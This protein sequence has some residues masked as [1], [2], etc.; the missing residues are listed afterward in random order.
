MV[1]SKWRNFFFE[2]RP[3]KWRALV[4]LLWNVIVKCACGFELVLPGNRCYEMRIGSVLKWWLLK[5]INWVC[6]R[7]KEKFKE[8]SS[9]NS[10]DTKLLP[11]I[12]SL[13]I[14][15]YP[16]TK[17]FFFYVN[18]VWIFFTKRIHIFHFQ[19]ILLIRFFFDK[20]CG[21][22]VLRQDLQKFTRL[23]LKFLLKFWCFSLKKKKP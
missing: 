10:S 2:V 23:Y 8:K 7:I 21:A 14:K 20:C 1:Q 17:N 3:P 19:S 9:M 15:W 5:W 13:S 18:F 6:R 22:I 11:D 12:Q 16:N 4:V